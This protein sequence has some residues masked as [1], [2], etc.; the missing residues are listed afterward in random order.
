MPSLSISE[1]AFG[2]QEDPILEHLYLSRAFKSLIVIIYIALFGLLMGMLAARNTV[3]MVLVTV[4][5]AFIGL[6]FVFDI[7]IFPMST[8]LS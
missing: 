8:R 7:F 2:V 3:S 6:F 5:P 1:K 4:G